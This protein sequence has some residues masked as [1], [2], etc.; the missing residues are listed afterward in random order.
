MLSQPM[1]LP[2]LS[3]TCAKVVACAS[4]SFLIIRKVEVHLTRKLRV[5]RG[6]LRRRLSCFLTG[7]VRSPP[8][9][10]SPRYDYEVRGEV[11]EVRCILR[12]PRV[13][14]V[15]LN[16]GVATRLLQATDPSKSQSASE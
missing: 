15:K 14:R 4:V 6:V 13:R 7:A 9:L 12:V 1:I 3:L 16:Y 11:R 8:S 5:P 10:P 2:A